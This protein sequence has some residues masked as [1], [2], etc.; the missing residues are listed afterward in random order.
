MIKS[1]RIQYRMAG[2]AINIDNA[3]GLFERVTGTTELVGWMASISIIWWT[4]GTICYCQNTIRGFSDRNS[5]HDAWMN[6]MHWPHVFSPWQS[7]AHIE[8]TMYKWCSVCWLNSHHI[9]MAQMGVW[10]YATTH[11]KAKIIQQGRWWSTISARS[12]DLLTH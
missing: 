11:V 7:M 6:M 12:L 2:N 1:Q 9:P 3:N 8:L 10:K 5:I 4:S